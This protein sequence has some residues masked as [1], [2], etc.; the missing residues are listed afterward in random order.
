[1]AFRVSCL[2]QL[3]PEHY[4]KVEGGDTTKIV[5][6]LQK[7]RNQDIQIKILDFSEDENRLI[8]SE[9]AINEA[10]QERACQVQGRRYC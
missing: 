7:L 1:M 2:S 4:P 9:R 10:Q 6:A 3:S 5:Q 8:V